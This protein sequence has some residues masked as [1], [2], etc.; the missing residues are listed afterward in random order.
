MRYDLHQQPDW[1]REQEGDRDKS[2]A[3]EDYAKVV[4][5]GK[6]TDT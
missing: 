5:P 1:M 3:E 2:K 6:G 4:R